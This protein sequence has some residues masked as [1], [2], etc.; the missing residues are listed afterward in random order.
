MTEVIFANI[1]NELMIDVA[2]RE[3]AQRMNVAM[4]RK[5]WLAGEDDIVITPEP[6]GREIKEYAAHI[7][8]TKLDRVRCYAP[9][10][11]DCA[12]LADRV[13]QDHELMQVLADH[14]ASHPGAAVTCFCPDRPTLDLLRELGLRLKHYD[15]EPS[16][17]TVAMFYR[18]NTKSGF[19]DAAQA[20]GLR[21]VEGR[22]CDGGGLLAA[23]LEL[24]ADWPAVIVKANRSSNGY[25]HTVIQIKDTDPRVVEARILALRQ[26][27]RPLPDAFVVERYMNFVRLPSVEIEVG[28][29]GPRL[30]YICDQRCR[31]NAW[32]GMWTPPQG[33]DD[34]YMETLIDIGMRFGRHVHGRGF[35]GVCDVDCGVAEDGVFVVTESNFRRTG[36]T[37]LDRLARTLVSENYLDTHVWLADTSLGRRTDFTAGVAALRAEGLEFD[38]ASKEGVVLTADTLRF[39]GKW[40]YLILARD[41][42][43]AQAIEARLAQV[44]ELTTVPSLLPS[45]SST[46]AAELV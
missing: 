22:H 20:I 35:R 30:L 38:D 17:E 33:V 34:A 15:A 37:Y 27:W 19:R 43:R 11:D 18:L 1:V 36:G 5:I 26:A 21:I 28:A 44:L 40:R 9:P 39:D 25:G 41:H 46:A 2:P 23:A 8:R 32:A 42:Q 14:A 31:N 3:Y 24:G 29:S 12:P 45:S 6:I 16:A 4:S 7:R 13:R 10:G